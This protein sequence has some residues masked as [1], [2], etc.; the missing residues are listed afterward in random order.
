MWEEGLWLAGSEAPH[1]R[2]AILAGD[3]SNGGLISVYYWGGRGWWVRQC[4]LRPAPTY[5]ADPTAAFSSASPP[6]LP[7]WTYISSGG[8]AASS[9]ESAGA[10]YP[11]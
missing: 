1:P 5:M 4:P 6:G 3:L 8:G 7:S 11:P 10:Q 9:Y 2:P